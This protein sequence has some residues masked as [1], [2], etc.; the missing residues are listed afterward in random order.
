MTVEMEAGY[1]PG[2]VEAA[3]DSWWK[4]QGYYTTDPKAAAAAGPEGRFTMVIPPPNV[5]GNLHL[6][7]GLT[8]SIEDCLARW[9]RMQG[10]PVMWLPGMDHAG[11]ATQSIVEKRLAKERGLTRHDLGREAFLKEVWAW[12]EQYG[13][14]IAHQMRHLGTSVDWDRTRFTLDEGLNVAV[15]EAFVR[16]YDEGLLYRQTRLVNWCCKLNTAIS[17]IEVDHIDL[18]KPTMLAV[19]GHDAAKKY[20]FGVIISFAYKVQG[21][22]EELVVATTRLETMLGDTAV[23]VHPDDPRYTHLHGAQLVHPFCDRLI[24][25]ITDGELVDMAFGTGAVKITPAHDPNDFACGRRHGLPEIVVLNDDGTINSNGGEFEGQMRFDARVAVTAALEAKGLYRGKEV[26]KMRLGLCSRSGDV[27]EPMPKPQW[28]IKCDAMAKRA[29]DAVRNGEL[30]IRPAFHEDEWFR[31]LDNIRDWCVSRQLW[32]G[33]RIPAYYAEV[34]GQSE[35][36]SNDE[37]WVPGRSEAEAMER[38]VERFGVPADQ[39]TLHQDPDVLD[40]W[41]SSALFPFS[42]FGWP[43]K[44]ADLAAFYPNSL[45]E[46]GHDILFFWVARMVMMGLQLT[47]QLPFKEIYLHAMVRDKY[48]RKMSKSLGNVIDPM[49]VIQGASLQQ[50]QDKLT[51][52]NLPP[53][54]IVKAQAGQAKEYP[55]GIPECGAD[56]MRMGLLAYTLQGRD[57]NLDINRVVAYRNFCNKLWNA[58][59]FAMGNLDPAVY[60]TALSVQGIVGHLV[61]ARQAGA[62]PAREAWILSRLQAATASA[63]EGFAAY[64]FANA[65]MAMH[66]F[67][68]HDLCDVYLEAVK[69]VMQGKEA[70]SVQG[71]TG[72]DAMAAASQLAPATSTAAVGAAAAGEGDFSAGQLAR[73]TLYT[74]LDVGLRLLHPVMPFVTEELWQRLP[75]RGGQWAEGVPDPASIMIAP[76]PQVVPELQAAD[77]EAAM[78][79]AKAINTALRSSRS[80]AKLPFSKTTENYVAATEPELRS[81]LAPLAQSIATLTSAGSLHFLGDFT[82]PDGVT[83]V[84][85]S[86]VLAAGVQLKGA[87]DAGAQIKKLN[88]DIAKKE[89]TVQA[90]Q[91]TVTNANAPEDVRAGAQANVDTLQREIAEMKAA[92]EMYSKW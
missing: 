26:N 30:A 22:E 6:G 36:R 13:G 25:V 57:I 74:C 52:G 51:A 2:Q 16:L 91:R 7:H 42:V 9:H 8:D 85:V 23:A 29:T 58:T 34:Q 72:A 45:L 33:H 60:S 10:K 18:E 71:L 84:V 40:T 5:T 53:K 32:W 44:T 92:V 73:Y 89:K 48:G 69:P 87:I 39:I 65:V 56:A 46:T 27:I 4:K 28:W 62:L 86:D 24:P 1:H 31:W 49:E 21:S 3:W 59:K 12:K 54:E 19:P 20:E 61:A 66:N 63:N 55:D 35:D 43:E 17:D 80:A 82:V 75:G 37:R 41:F 90:Q 67:W 11:I 79:T 50:L 88:K 83:S 78:E 14:N 77:I 38:A 70:V 15:N 76:Y 68:L 47:D 81:A 64:E